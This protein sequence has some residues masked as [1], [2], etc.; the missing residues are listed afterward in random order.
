MPTRFTAREDTQRPEAAVLADRRGP[1]A[2]GELLAIRRSRETVV[3]D[4]VYEL[5]FSWNDSTALI[6]VGADGAVRPCRPL[7]DRNPANG[8]IDELRRRQE[9]NVVEQ[10]PP[11]TRPSRS[12]T[13]PRH[14]EPAHQACQADAKSPAVTSINAAAASQGDSPRLRNALK[15][16]RS[17]V[18]PERLGEPESKDESCTTIRARNNHRVSTTI[19]S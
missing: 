13:R 12:A 5:P 19:S 8:G 9:A 3:G 6:G 10:R 18:E 11:K 1:S 15:E 17:I 2:R 7:I 4:E 14:R 16:L